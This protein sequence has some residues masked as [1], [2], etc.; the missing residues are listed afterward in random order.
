VS[1]TSPDSL[2]EDML[3]IHRAI[4]R[5][6]TVSKERA[7]AFVRDGF[8]DEATRR[9]FLDYVRS[10][11][12]LTRGHHATEEAVG[13]PA[14]QE[15]MPEVPWDTLDAQ[16]RALLPVLD[17]V[18]AGVE[19]GKKMSAGGPWLSELETSLSRLAALWAEHIGLE[20]RFLSEAALDRVSSR[21]EQ[22][23]MGR[24]MAEHGSTL[25]QPAPLVLSFFYFNLEPK[26]RTR[27]AA[28]MP[29]PLT[30]QLIPV[31]WKDAWAP[32]RPFFLP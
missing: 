14:L 13:F 23:E 5:G 30:Q 25:A 6:M 31:D 29:P 28:K 7:R 10:L 20:E 18:E 27:L 4:T 26:D 15:R 8:P 21:Q 16:H 19:A 17:S 11:V 1:T 32:M 22:E 12:T 3:R 9:G 24:K 2:A